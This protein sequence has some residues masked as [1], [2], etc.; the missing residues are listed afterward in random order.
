MRAERDSA[1][2]TA[3]RRKANQLVSLANCSAPTEI[4]ID[5]E[6]HS[7]YLQPNCSERQW[8]QMPRRKAGHETFCSRFSV[9]DGT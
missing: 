5:Q 6:M 3:Q 7:H 2:R 1:G 9:I 4:L 8:E